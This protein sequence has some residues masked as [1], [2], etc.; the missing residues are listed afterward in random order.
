MNK[1][2]KHLLRCKL[3]SKKGGWVEKLPEV[4][5]AV[6]TAPQSAIGETLFSL[7][8]GTEAV[9]PTETTLKTRRVDRFSTADNELNSKLL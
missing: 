5:W 4:L 6:R 9:L 3:E 8:F 1:V 7:A 2:I